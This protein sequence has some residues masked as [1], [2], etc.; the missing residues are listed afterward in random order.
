GAALRRA[1]AE[2][3]S[4]ARPGARRGG[5]SP[6]PCGA[7]TRDGHSHAGSRYRGQ[8]PEQAS[9]TGLS[10]ADPASPWP[11][12]AARS[13]RACRSADRTSRSTCLPRYGSPRGPRRAQP[14]LRR[15]LPDPDLDRGLTQSLGQLGDLV[16]E[17]LLPTR[18]LGLARLNTGLPAL[19]ELALP[20]PDRLLG[21]LL[22][23]GSLGDRDLPLQHGQHNAELLLRRDRR[24]TTH[25]SDLSI[26]AL[27]QQLTTP[28]T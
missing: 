28:A 8:R 23:A 7:P 9:A 19:Q 16:L 26:G 24:W 4:P 27:P 11:A 14:T 6:R 3:R 10:A 25:D 20:V 12:N 15:L 22:A 1:A 18:G 13:V 17:L 5:S 2:A 21:D